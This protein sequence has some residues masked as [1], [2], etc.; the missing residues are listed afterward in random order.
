[1]IKTI[2]DKQLAR[3]HTQNHT[4]IRHIRFVRLLKERKKK[5]CPKCHNNIT[6][7]MATTNKKDVDRIV[8]NHT[9]KKYGSQQEK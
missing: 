2:S 9:Q 4:T 6:K 8:P 1:M 5:P 3:A 7:L